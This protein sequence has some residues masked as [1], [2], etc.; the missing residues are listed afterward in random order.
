MFCK[1]RASKGAESCCSSGRVFAGEAV[2]Q[3]H[4]EG[5]GGEQ[6]QVKADLIVAADGVNSMCRD[7]LEELVRSSF[8]LSVNFKRHVDINAGCPLQVQGL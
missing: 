2:F 8:S 6:I 1:F 3:K 4:P 7:L 5:S